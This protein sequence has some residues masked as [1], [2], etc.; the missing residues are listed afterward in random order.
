MIKSEMDKEAFKEFSKLV[1][2]LCNYSKRKVY[3]QHLKIMLGYYLWKVKSE[4][5][6]LI[7]FEINPKGVEITFFSDYLDIMQKIGFVEF[8]KNFY[9]TIVIAKKKLEVKAYEGYQLQILKEIVEK[10]LDELQD[11]LGINIPYSQINEKED[12]V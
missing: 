4:Y 3:M 8:D 11:I 5:D 10:S 1:L 9:G 6:E 2:Y 12:M 7:K